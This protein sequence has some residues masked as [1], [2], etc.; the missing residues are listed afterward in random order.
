MPEI[1][2]DLLRKRAEHN[3]G[4]ISTLEELTLHQEEL[5][6]INEVLGMTCRKLK[7]LY[8]QN[9]LIRKIENLLHCKELEYLNL[10]LNNIS[11]IE[12]LQNAEFLKKLDLTVN[13]IDVDTL[14]E[15]INH[16]VP[17]DRLRDV[18]F[19]GNPCEADW[20][21][22][23]AYVIAK[24]PQITNLDGVEITRSMQL[25][26]LQRLPDLERE[27]RSL[28]NAKRR[29]KEAKAEGSSKKKSASTASSASAA[30]S[31]NSK[32]KANESRV[33]ELDENNNEVVV[34]DGSDEEGDTKQDPNRPYDPDEMTDNTPEARERIYRELAKQKA[35]KAERDNMN[36]P[37]ERDYE[38]EQKAAV[39]EIRRKEEESGEREIKQKNEG[40]WDFSWD[41]DSKPGML[42]LSIPVPR[43]LDSSLIDVDVHPT[44]V[45]VIIKS[46]TLRLR[47]LCEVQAESS[48]CQ[49]AKTNG[50][51]MIIMPKVNKNENVLSHN[52]RN[53]TMDSRIDPQGG[54]ANPS[55]A[56]SATSSARKEGGAGSGKG[57]IQGGSGGSSGSSAPS[58]PKKLSM[59]EQ[60]IAD[61]LAASTSASAAASAPDSSLSGASFGASKL[62]S[63]SVDIANIVKRRPDKDKDKENVTTA[64]ESGG[65]GEA[66][67]E[68]VFGRKTSLIAEL[69]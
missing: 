34:D 54:N 55:N 51:L 26:A 9:N 37:K 1:T 67:L 44:Y 64:S 16:L 33:V 32:I 30:S 13:F 40:G 10:A 3:E 24:L 19:M 52:A 48:K 43:H 62:P 57:K 8:L 66:A 27:L 6:S 46:K 53:V 45:S 60:M 22:F 65:A 59:Q 61:A 50:A 14:E 42:I 56:R 17:R 28:A 35:E 21:G 38:K 18:Y 39:E 58:R 25:Q 23:K 15:S 4:M 11:K 41:E 2:R 31:S 5:E 47:T 29:E 20:P 36:K 49:R 68:S 7:I 12:G 63:A 69:D